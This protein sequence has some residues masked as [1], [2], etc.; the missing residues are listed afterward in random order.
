MSPTAHSEIGTSGI[1]PHGHPVGQAAPFHLPDHGVRL[2]M[3]LSIPWVSLNPSP[4][5]QAERSLKLYKRG[6]S[7]PSH[8]VS[9]L[10]P[11]GSAPSPLRS[12]LS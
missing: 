1:S 3:A 2:S 4:T 5:W 8:A 9:V 12:P 10:L 6:H 11:D 7:A